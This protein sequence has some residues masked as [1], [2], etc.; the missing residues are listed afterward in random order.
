M[1]AI[2]DQKGG[3]PPDSPFYSF[4][5]TFEVF[6]EV[7]VVLVLKVGEV[8]AVR[9]IALG[10]LVAD[11]EALSYIRLS[12]FE[13]RSAFGVGRVDVV[14]REFVF[15]AV[16]HVDEFS[17][18]IAGQ[19]C[20]RDGSCDC[21]GLDDCVWVHKLFFYF[22]LLFSPVALLEKNHL[23]ARRKA[24]GVTR[25]GICAGPWRES[26]VCRAQHAIALARVIFFRQKQTAE[27]NKNGFEHGTRSHRKGVGAAVTYLTCDVVWKRSNVGNS[28]EDRRGRS[29][30]PAG[31]KARRNQ[32][33]VRRMYDPESSRRLLGQTRRWSGR[34]VPKR[35]GT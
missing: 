3:L 1:R 34:T 26:C 10:G 6:V 2:S 13:F 19:V 35:P 11:L 28:R 9:P 7:A 15:T 22:S 16:C 29:I 33:A 31:T 21:Y 8:L 20:E 32:F 5:K 23:R 12:A 4:A 18:H 24:G 27:K 14:V 30:G 17:D 25:P